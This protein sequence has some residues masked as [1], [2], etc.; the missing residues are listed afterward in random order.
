M[1][2]AFKPVITQFLASDY[3]NLYAITK[4]NY[5]F[6]PLDLIHRSRFHIGVT[7]VWT[8]NPGKDCLCPETVF[9]GKY[10]RRRIGASPWAQWV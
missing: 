8:T 5:G 9:A 4:N 7:A 6:H 1:F 10:N 3:E 2:G